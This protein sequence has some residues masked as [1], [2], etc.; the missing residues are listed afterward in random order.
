M[1]F[2]PIQ[3]RERAK[4]LVSF[5]GMDLGP[6][7]WPTDFDAA[8]EWKDRAWLLFEVKHGDK[9]VPLGL[10]S[11]VG[12]LSHPCEF[13]FCFNQTGTRTFP[14]ARWEKGNGVNVIRTGMASGNE[15]ADE[16][17]ATFPVEFAAEVVRNF[18]D[19]S[20]L[21]LFGGTGTTL[22]AAEQLGRT[23][24]MMELDPHYCDLVLKRWEDMTGETAERL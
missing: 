10:P 23:C 21:D 18:T 7:L 16:H 4:Q 17:N 22:I 24:Y 1:T 19:S 15:Y 11:Q 14:H 13:V 8:I 9:A 2:Q 20:V 6:R 3:S 12:L 5:D